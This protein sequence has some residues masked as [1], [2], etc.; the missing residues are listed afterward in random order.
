MSRQIGIVTNAASGSAVDES[1]LRDSWAEIDVTTDWLPT[2]AE[3]PGT[4][5]AAHAIARGADTVVAC[6]GD[7]TVRAVI[8]G[9]A[10]TGTALGVVPLGTGNLLAGNLGLPSG[11]DA[12]PVAAAGSTRTIDVGV[13]N[14]ERFAVMAGVGL[15]AALIGGADSTLKRRV[16]SAAYILSALK[17]IG[18]LRS[19]VF[20]AHVD[21]DGRPWGGRTPLVLVGNCGTVSGG[22]DVFPDAAPDDGLL[23]V[24]VVTASDVRG[25]LSIAVRLVL[26]R[27]QRPHLVRRS[28]ATR[29]HVR[30]DRPMAY[31]LDGEVRDPTRELTISVE[32]AALDVRVGD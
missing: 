20:V 17:Q 11:L 1:T 28:R 25:W 18:R 27:P 4:Q 15:D 19:L 29:V 5:Q 24:A 7:G 30:L 9:V 3:S 12:I 26:G 13:V 10:G 8:E 31:Q 21:V 22:V 14:G 16:G 6:G 32:R 23:D 2:T